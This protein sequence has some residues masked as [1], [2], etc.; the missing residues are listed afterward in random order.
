MGTN[1]RSSKDLPLITIGITCYN[2]EDT[3]GRAIDGAR[4]QDWPH[5][6]IIVVDDGSADRSHEIIGEIVEKDRRVKCI[7]HDRNRGYA[8]ALNTII[9]ASRGEYIAIFDDDDESVPDRL[10]KQWRKLTDYARAHDTDLVFCYSNRAVVVH[11]GGHST[12]A[13]AIGRNP[14]EPSGEAV[15]DFLLW[16]YED[17]E[18]VWGQFGS[19]TMFASKQTF[20][21]VGP[22][23]EEFRRGAE[24]D[25]A[26]RLAF[27]G[28]HFI[29]VDEPLITQYKTSTADKSGAI[30]LTNSLRLREKHETYLKKKRVY[31]ASVALAR[32]RFYYATRRMPLS[33]FY[34]AL[35][36]ICSP[37]VVLP[38]EL[39][40]RR[41]RKRSVA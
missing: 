16:H 15:A 30:P 2:A 11:D 4:S 14:V 37:S 7:R 33:R 23:D 31:L 36:C 3:I 21:D 26:I 13:Y 34:L 24:W 32:S 38:N 18:C 22:W 39:A 10:S 5:L 41:R 40:K 9:E 29:S 8:G 27:K 25:L 28:G 19:C 35:A 20:A 17:P 12:T 6:E 1:D